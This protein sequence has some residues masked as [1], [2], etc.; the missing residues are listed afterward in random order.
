MSR[1]PLPVLFSLALFLCSPTFAQPDSPARLVYPWLSFSTQFES[2]L[3]ANNYGETE[4]LIELVAR[5]ADGTQ[6]VSNRTL[7]PGGFLRESSQQLFPDLQE[8]AGFSVVLHSEAASLSGRWITYNRE[9]TSGKSPAQG[10]AIGTDEV[11]GTKGVRLGRTVEYGFLPTDPD[12]FAAPVVINLGDAATDVTLYVYN[13]SGTLLLEDRDSLKDLEPMRPFAVTLSELLPQID[14]DVTVVA[15]STDQTLSGVTFVFNQNREPAIGNVS[16]LSATPGQRK[17]SYDFSQGDLGWQMDFADYPVGESNFYELS[18]GLEQLPAELGAA[19]TALYLNGNNHSDDLFMFAK[20]EVTGLKPSQ[21]YRVHLSV[22]IA[23]NAGSECAGIGGAPGGSVYFK[24]GASQKE[25]L[26]VA[27]DGQ[28]LMNIDKGN[29]STSGS[30]MQ[31]IGDIGVDTDCL[32]GEY[33][34]KRLDATRLEVTAQTN[35]AGTLWLIV[36]TDSGFEGTTRIYLTGVDALLT[37]VD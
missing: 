18:S 21:S 27:T 28:L 29:Q 35:E 4:A 3:V 6:W 22:T 25:P 13:Q 5:R 11:D 15:Q 2:T 12:F 30:D 10:V 34:F 19:R 7:P 20:R 8:G 37:P 23:S 26:P 32:D 17:L 14:E 16:G 24:A 9:G 31:A 33:R 1:H 36:G